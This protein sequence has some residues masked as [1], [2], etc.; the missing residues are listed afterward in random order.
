MNEHT[1]NIRIANFGKRLTNSSSFG[2]LI[3]LIV[4]CVILSIASDK[5]LTFDNVLSV[6]RAFSFIA[7]M[8][9]GEC[10]VI[11]TGG[12]DLSVS[13][14][15]AISGV[16]CALGIKTYDLPVFIAILLGL[17][18]AMIFGALNGILTTKVKMPPFI[19]T[20]GMLSV[21]RGL[22]YSITGGYPIPN[23]PVAF[24][25]LGQGYMLGVPFPIIMLILLGIVFTV[26]LQSTILGRR[27]F[28]IGGNEKAAEITGVKVDRVKITVYII[29]S[30]LAGLAGIMTAARLGVAQST[31]GI[32]YELD[33]IA[34]VI[35]GGA[36][37]SG[38][39]GTV[40][41]AILGA[42]IMGVL[43]NGL[44]LLSVSAYWQQTVI[45]CVVILA[46]ALDRLRYLRQ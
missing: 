44:V 15:F 40:V 7:I 38:G 27:I 10:F 42:A 2:I 3:I 13:S 8:A 1:Q 32:G 45:G 20:L 22:A 21:A 39:R 16:V 31:A 5:F 35:I 26:F 14:V 6:G 4:M 9:I 29:S 43:K 28:A 17:A 18:V 19:V 41:G 33:T 23:F 25:F 11:I 12:I 37:V 34:A 30:A 36:S 24:K 46:V